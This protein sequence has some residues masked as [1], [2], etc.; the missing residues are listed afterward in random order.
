MT[1]K[2]TI[3][4]L[5]DKTLVAEADK[6]GINRSEASRQGIRDEIAK[7]RNVYE[8]QRQLKKLKAEKDFGMKLKNVVLE[9]KGEIKKYN[10]KPEDIDKDTYITEL[11]RFNAEEL[12]VDYKVLNVLMYN[13]M[14]G[15]VLVNEI[16]DETRESLVEKL[17]GS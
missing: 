7:K 6:Y 10:L 11:I 4:V 1:E 5:I 12:N 15:S 8:R 2:T 14:A 13:I 16:I 9:L 3:S 17:G